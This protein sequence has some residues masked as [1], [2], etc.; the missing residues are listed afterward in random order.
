MDKV[1]RPLGPFYPSCSLSIA[2]LL[3]LIPPRSQ[4]TVAIAQDGGT[5]LSRAIASRWTLVV[6]DIELIIQFCLAYHLEVLADAT[7]KGL[8]GGLSV[9]EGRGRGGDRSPEQVWADVRLVGRPNDVRRQTTRHGSC[10]GDGNGVSGTDSGQRGR[11]CGTRGA[12]TGNSREGAGRCV[13]RAGG[14][15]GGGGWKGANA[16]GEVRGFGERP[17]RGD[18]VLAGSFDG[19]R[20]T[21]RLRGCRVAWAVH[22]RGQ[23]TRRLCN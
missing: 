19:G 9:V 15:R 2:S 11:G 20:G 8:A 4:G 7:A 18:G 22:A 3:V 13:G 17:V 5:V 14:G 21:G 6:Q 23:A 10:L 16:A 1:P 12:W